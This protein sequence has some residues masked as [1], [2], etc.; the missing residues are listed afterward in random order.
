[1]TVVDA[2]GHVHSIFFEDGLL[3]TNGTDPFYWGLDEDEA[4]KLA[5]Y[6]KA[7]FT[8]KENEYPL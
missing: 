4:W 5:Q 8:Q 7:Y 3:V 2:D 1:M 6:I